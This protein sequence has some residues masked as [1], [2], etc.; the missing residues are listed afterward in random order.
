QNKEIKILPLLTN[1]FVFLSHIDSLGSAEA[2]K[3]HVEEAS[4]DWL[5][6][7]NLPINRIVSGSAGAYLILKILQKNIPS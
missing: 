1:F 4:Q 7:A 3:N 6:R 5:K 2:L